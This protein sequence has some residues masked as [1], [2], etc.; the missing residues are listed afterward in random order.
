MSVTG[1]DDRMGPL[2]PRVG[3]TKTTATAASGAVINHATFSGLRGVRGRVTLSYPKAQLGPNNFF[4]AQLAGRGD[5]PAKVRGAWTVQR[6]G[7]RNTAG[8]NDESDSQ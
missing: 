7:V 6:V 3:A 2:P 8:C 4:C 1:S 5:C